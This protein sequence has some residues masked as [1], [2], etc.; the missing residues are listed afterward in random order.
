MKP[1]PTTTLRP[2]A[3]IRPCLRLWPLAFGGALLP[4]G[5]LLAA[6]WDEGGGDLNYA[7]AANW[8]PDGVPTGAGAVANIS[9]TANVTHNTA[10]AFTTTGAAANLI[11]GGAAGVTTVLNVLPGS[12]TLTFGGNGYAT[13]AQIG[14]FEGNGTINLSGGLVRIGTGLAGDDASINVAT[15]TSGTA[16]ATGAIN[17]SGGTLQVGRRILIAANSTS[18]TGTVTLSGTGVIKMVSTG[19]TGE[20]DLGMIRLGA[21]TVTLNLDGGELIGR[22]IR[23]D[24]GTAF[25][26][27]YYNGTRFTL[28]GNSGT[29]LSALIGSGGSAVNQLKNGGLK[30][31]TAGFTGMIARGLA[32]FPGDTGILTKEGLGTLTLT[33]ANS[34][35]G[36][37]TVRG[38]VLAF[39]SAGT[40]PAGNLIS[41]GS[42]ATLRFDRNDTFG[43][44]NTAVMQAITV[45]GGTITNGATF[46]TTLGAVTL[47]AG[48]I[49]STGGAN[50]S[51][52]SF[53]L[54]GPLT[55][56]GTAASAISGSGTHSQM[57][58]G[59][60][61]ADSQTTFDVA[62]ATGDA[63]ADLTISVPLLNN[64]NAAFTSVATGLIKNGNGTMALTAINIYTG[65][66]TVESGTLLLENDARLRFAIGADSGINN[67]LTGTGTVILHGDFAIDTTAA[68]ALTAGSWPL[69]DVASLPGPYGTTFTVVDPDGSPWNDAGGNQWTKDAGSGRTWT[70]NETTGTL[71][72]S[73]GSSGSFASWAA[74]NGVTGGPNGDSDHDTIPNLVEYA[75]NLNPAAS[76]GSAG[77]FTGGLLSFAKRAVA[78]TNGD[79][80]YTI[81]R[82][83]D[84]GQTEAWEAVIPTFNDATAITFQL[85]TG[86][87]PSSFV[88]LLIRQNP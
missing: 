22:G 47:N 24:A 84:L 32:N 66:T 38:G 57:V 13:A 65:H 1:R 78:V 48:T 30:V 73:G 46:F 42:G 88:R 61:T 54:R 77:T 12:G 19:L 51:F 63:L 64:R 6:T 33:A 40:L 59:T 16:P 39:S 82:S 37:T 8:N 69:E 62:N 44:H 15:S 58:V 5:S 11:L 34:Y 35:T 68:A 18:R 86:P 85:A 10:S 28:N 53:S 17:V 21:G 43:N 60:S 81:Q 4:A 49:N 72:L 71:S 7:T 67:Q 26:S 23:Q 45:D 55:I 2:D 76:D 79:I 20:G 3:K 74:E 14:A 87:Q 80:T 9:V 36:V 75:L 27:I 52:P 50:A 41:V 83:K 25:S 29:G 70:F 56:G 31:E